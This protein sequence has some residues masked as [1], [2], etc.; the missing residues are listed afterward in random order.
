MLNNGKPQS[1]TAGGA[2]T[3]F[4]DAEESF[5]DAL[6]VFRSDADAAVSDADVHVAAHAA[7]ANADGGVGGRIVD[8]VAQQVGHGGD[9][10]R[11]VP[12]DKRT[13]GGAAVDGDVGVVGGELGAL[14]GVV[15]DLVDGDGFHVG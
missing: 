10:E 8:G 6:L 15:N 2:G 14:Q 7:L 13:G 3:G 11:F 9:Q 1:G 12:H 5:E 4:V